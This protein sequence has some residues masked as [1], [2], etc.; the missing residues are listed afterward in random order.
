MY[1]FVDHVPKE[2]DR[3]WAGNMI[4]ETLPDYY[5][6]RK[7]VLTI[8]SSID[9]QITDGET[10]IQAHDQNV[11]VFYK[12]DEVF[13][14]QYDLMEEYHRHCHSYVNCDNNKVEMSSPFAAE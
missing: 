13:A 6:V 10:L 7:F 11:Q 14:P 4:K 5:N 9:G 2:H 3:G 12:I 8:Y 1:I